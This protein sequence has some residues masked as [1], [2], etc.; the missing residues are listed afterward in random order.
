MAARPVIIDCDPG[1]DDAINLFL[2]MSSPD[3]LDILGVTVVA[4]NAPLAMTER[5]ARGICEIAGR[6]D[7]PVFAGCR[8]PLSRELLTAE[9]VHGATGLDGIEFAEP[10][11]TLRETHAVDFIVETLLACD[12]AAVTLVSTGPLTNVASAMQRDARVLRKVAGIVLMG[13]TM[14]EAGNCTPSAEYN[15]FADPDAADIVFHSGCPITVFGLDAT[16]QLLTTR[17]FRE[18]IRAIDSPVGRATGDAI[19]FMSRWEGYRQ[20]LSGV[21]LH[22]PCTVAFLLRRDLFDGKS[23]NLRVETASELTLGHTSVDFWQVTDRAANVTWIHRVDA[24]AV[25]DLLVERLSRSD[26]RSR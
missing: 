25:L 10:G 2:A 22:D 19:D 16:H 13:G 12:D 3:E 11:L 20:R 15:V 9:M 24:H 5:N 1:H 21:P 8:R 26:G 6:I 4:G 14:K 18:R 7:I 17:E 23:C